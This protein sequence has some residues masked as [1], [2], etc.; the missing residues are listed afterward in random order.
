MCK[1][2]SKNTY[3]SCLFDTFMGYNLAFFDI[4]SKI[5]ALKYKFFDMYTKFHKHLAKIKNQV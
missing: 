5:K 1:T 3:L 2:T 4:K